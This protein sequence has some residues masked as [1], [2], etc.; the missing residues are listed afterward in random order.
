MLLPSII[1]QPSYALI[2]L[3]YIFTI[4]PLRIILISLCSAWDGVNF[5]HSSLYCAVLWICG[6]NSV[7]NISVLAFAEQSL[8]SIKVFFPLAQWGQGWGRA[9]YYRETHLGQLI[10][11]DQMDIL[12]PMSLCPEIKTGRKKRK[13]KLWHFSCQVTIV[14]AGPLLPR[15][16]LDITGL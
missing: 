2:S 4:Q 11:T 7:G 14:S 8:H 10:P 5:H 6:W 3:Y 12:Y 9:K 16:R 13:G 1:H 15:R